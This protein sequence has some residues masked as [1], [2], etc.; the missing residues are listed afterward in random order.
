MFP[1]D[2]NNTEVVEITKWVKNTEGLS[3][4]KNS[5]SQPD[6]KLNVSNRR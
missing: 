5:R 3:F 4:K 2:F 6:N 1:K